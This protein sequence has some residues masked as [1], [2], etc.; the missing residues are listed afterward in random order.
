MYG[1]SSEKWSVLTRRPCNAVQMLIPWHTCLSERHHYTCAF[2]VE[3]VVASMLPT[4]DIFGEL[5]YEGFLRMVLP[6]QASEESLR[7]AVLRLFAVASG[8]VC[9][10]FACV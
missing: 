4:A 2:T 7:E 3:D 1:F 9:A 10:S 5:S 6:S 8:G